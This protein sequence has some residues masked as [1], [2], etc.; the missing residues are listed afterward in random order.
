MAEERFRAE[1][2]RKLLTAQKVATMADLKEAL[3][4]DVD[5]TVFRKLRELSYLTSYS[6]RS[7]YYSLT[8]VADFD[9]LGLWSFRSVWFS[10]FGTLVATAEACVQSSEAGYF[11][12]ELQNV[13]HVEVKDVLRKLVQGR[14]LCREVVAGRYLYCSP[15]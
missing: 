3:G 2:L 1:G 15:T 4:T 7:S 6:H 8:D 14:R 11:P 13:L 12:D 9:G 10:K 5:M